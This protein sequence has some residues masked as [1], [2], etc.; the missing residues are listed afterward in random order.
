MTPWG[1]HRPLG[2]VKGNSDVHLTSNTRD[3]IAY[4]FNYKIREH[5]TSESLISS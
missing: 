1:L 2:S 4:L 5:L 3:D